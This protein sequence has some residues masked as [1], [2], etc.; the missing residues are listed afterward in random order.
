MTDKTTPLVPTVIVDKNGK[1]T[2]VH[3]KPNLPVKVAG[4]SKPVLPVAKPT[5]KMT[6]EEIANTVIK[7]IKNTDPPKGY[8]RIVI[9][10]HVRRSLLEAAKDVE[11]IRGIHSMF[12]ALMSGGKDHYQAAITIINELKFDGDK[13]KVRTLYANQDILMERP[14]DVL[15]IAYFGTFLFESGVTEAGKDG[16]IPSLGNHLKARSHHSLV[17][18][19]QFG[20]YKVPPQIDYRNDWDYMDMVERN[21]DKLEQLMSYRKLRGIQLDADG[22]DLIDE[23]DFHAY[24]TQGAV[25]D[26]WL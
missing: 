15:D 5:D 19:S 13:W 21:Q 9:H 18:R 25:A 1:M 24:L 10:P 16:H 2:T 26:G 8:T 11:H 23:A 14:N 12:E 17:S 7:R 20:D 6:G 22:N 3:K 4:I